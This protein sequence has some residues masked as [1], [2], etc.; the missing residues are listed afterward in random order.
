MDRH[1]ATQLRKWAQARLG[2]VKRLSNGESQIN[3]GC[4]GR[5]QVTSEGVYI[6]VSTSA[7]I[8]A[9]SILLDKFDNLVG[10]RQRQVVALQEFL[11]RVIGVFFITYVRGD[12]H[13]AR[14]K[15]FYLKHYREA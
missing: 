2:I 3:S 10:I 13:R 15:V 12:F 1:I 8:D 6:L 4:M 14:G 11:G 9:C 7:N 5:T